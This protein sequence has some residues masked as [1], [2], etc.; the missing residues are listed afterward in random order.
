MFTDPHTQTGSDDETNA[1]PLPK[2]YN[3]FR[4][5]CEDGWW[6][7]M[8]PYAI[9]EPLFREQRPPH[10]PITAF[11]HL[12]GQRALT[13]LQLAIAKAEALAAHKATVEKVAA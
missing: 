4:M 12:D 9:T 5:W 7:V 1:I 11:A 3:K 6:I 8:Q 13:E 10:D 2:R